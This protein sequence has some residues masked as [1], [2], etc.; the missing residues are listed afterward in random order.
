MYLFNCQ[1]FM[2]KVLK[3]QLYN[4]RQASEKVIHSCRKGELVKPWE[5]ENGSQN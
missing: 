2:L 1:G 3:R 4:Q 5:S